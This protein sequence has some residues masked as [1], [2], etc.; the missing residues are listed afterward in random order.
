MNISKVVAVYISPTGNVRKTVCAMAEAIAK[1]L[2]VPMTEDDFTLPAAH[3][4]I[5]RWIAAPIATHSSGLMPLN[6]SLPVTFFTASCTAGI[7][8]DPP[9][10][11]TFERS[12]LVTPASAIAFFIGSIVLFTSSDRGYI[13]HRCERYRKCKRKGYGYRQGAEHHDH[14]FNEAFG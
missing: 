9:T 4:K 12:L 11:I 13:R 2:D 10:R 8:V 3:Q 14:F 6:G 1:K 7:L 5:R